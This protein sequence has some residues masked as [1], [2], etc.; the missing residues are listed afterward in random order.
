MEVQPISKLISAGSPASTTC[1]TDRQTDRQRQGRGQGGSTELAA[2]GAQGSEDRTRGEQCLVIKP[3]PIAGALRVLN[4]QNRATI[5]VDIGYPYNYVCVLQSRQIR[6]AVQTTLK[7]QRCVSDLVE[8]LA[9][10]THTTSAH[11]EELRTNHARPFYRLSQYALQ[12][13]KAEVKSNA[14]NAVVECVVMYKLPS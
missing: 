11:H 4:D 1:V 13:H 2:N 3:M 8:Y 5:R 9:N 6:T 14:E 10:K 12:P 7:N